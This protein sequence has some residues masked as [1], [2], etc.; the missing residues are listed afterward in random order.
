MP[1]LELGLGS[2]SW[3]RMGTACVSRCT[4]GRATAV[5]RPLSMALTAGA[6]FSLA[7]G[8]AMIYLL[9]LRVT[10]WM[11]LPVTRVCLPLQNTL[12]SLS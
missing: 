12:S 10:K 3:A 11:S 7:E 1:G 5:I 6:S 9:R 4:V 8:A 2:L